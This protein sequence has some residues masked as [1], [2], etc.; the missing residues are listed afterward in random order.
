MRA[1]HRA[2]LPVP[3]APPTS[4][5]R[6]PELRPSAEGSPWTVTPAASRCPQPPLRC[7]LTACFLSIGSR[8]CPAPRPDANPALCALRASAMDRQT[9]A[10]ERSHSSPTIKPARR[11]GP[12]SESAFP[13]PPRKKKKTRKAIKQSKPP[14]DPFLLPSSFFILRPACANPRTRSILPP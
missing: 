3:P 11:P 8:P 5:R 2:V 13:R 10:T 1:R 4:P 7:V 12:P 14:A 9:R 6:Q